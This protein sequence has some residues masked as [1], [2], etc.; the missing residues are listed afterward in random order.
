MVSDVRGQ[1]QERQ[2]VDQAAAAEVEA[3][4]FALGDEGQLGVLGRGHLSFSGQ[5]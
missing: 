4:E 2:K 5:G 3:L 1:R